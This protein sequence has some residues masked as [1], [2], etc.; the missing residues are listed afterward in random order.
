MGVALGLCFWLA[1]LSSRAT[2]RVVKFN[3]I[4]KPGKLLRIENAAERY[5]NPLGPLGPVSSR[6]EV[7]RDLNSRTFTV[8]TSAETDSLLQTLKDQLA[9]EDKEVKLLKENIKSLS[10]AND[11]LTHR[12]RDMES[13]LDR[14]SGPK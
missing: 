8:Y 5:Y 14:Q 9:A 12:I 7:E 3:T 10:D 4:D 2:E 13:K 11:A 6:P 1:L